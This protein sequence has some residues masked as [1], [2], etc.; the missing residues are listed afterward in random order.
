MKRNLLIKPQ[1]RLQSLII[2]CVLPPH[3]GPL[4][5]GEG[6]TAVASRS[7]RCTQIFDRRATVLPLHWGEGRG[8]GERSAVYLRASFVVLVLSL[9]ALLGGCTMMPKYQRPAAPVGGSWP[10]DSA[11]TNA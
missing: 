7:I 4:P 3:P 6:V 1:E 5:K 2:G 9:G 10:S 11:Q 8:E